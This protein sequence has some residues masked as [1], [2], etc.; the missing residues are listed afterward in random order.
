MPSILRLR[1]S[2]ALACLFVATS[3]KVIA[4]DTP[5]NQ[6]ADH[7]N[8]SNAVALHGGTVNLSCTGLT[9]A[10]AQMLQSTIPS[11]I[12]RNQ[13]ETQEQLAA[14]ES[15]IKGL[16]SAGQYGNL[17][18]RALELSERIVQTYYEDGGNVKP[19]AANDIVIFHMPAPDA[20]PGAILEWMRHASRK[21]RAFYAQKVVELHDEFAQTHLHD[22]EID[23]FAES[24]KR[25]DAERAIDPRVP[26]WAMP[27]QMTEIPRIAQGLLELAQQLP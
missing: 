12:E 3:S 19:P 8:C 22:A 25:M 10:E 27:P 26:D 18:G 21:F 4:Q 7:V 15:L 11:L 1:E 5:I 24:Y 14:I 17:K 16:Q 20:P 23:S 9:K 6:K 13:H 2:I